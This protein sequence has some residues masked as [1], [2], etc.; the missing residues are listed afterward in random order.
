MEECTQML[1]TMTLDC[2]ATII[3]DGLDEL[4]GQRLDLLASL[5]TLID[6]SSSIV[7]ILIS[8]REDTDIAQALQDALS[9]RVSACDNSADIEKFVRYRTTSVI[10]NQKLLGGSVS[11]FLKGHLISALLE[12][13]GGMFLWP[14]LQL[15]YFCDRQIFKIE[16]DIM[17]ALKTLPPTMVGTFERL[18]ARID[19]Y[20]KHGKTIATRVF[21]WLLAAERA[22]SVSELICAIR[23]REKDFDVECM[24]EMVYS[25][26]TILDL[27]CNFVVLDEDLGQFSFVHASV[28]EYLQLLPEYS[29]S[30]NNYTAAK[31]CLE[32]FIFGDE[33]VTQARSI[34]SQGSSP[35]SSSDVD[36]GLD[37]FREYA[38]CHWAHH[39]LKT[40]DT[41]LK[42]KL[43]AI[44][45]QFTS[46]EEAM[47]FGT[48]EQWLQDVKDMV[49]SE[50]PQPSHLK[51]LNAILNDSD[52]PMFVACVYGMPT[53]LEQIESE[54]LRTGKTV[55]YNAKNAHGASALYVC[56][57]YG[58]TV[59]LQFLLHRRANTDATGGFFGNPL[60]ASAFHGHEDVVRILVEENANL[61]AL[62]KFTSAL[63]AAMAGGNEQVVKP[64]LEASNITSR[65]ELEK[66]LSR[67]SYDG[68]Y[69]VVRHILDLLVPRENDNCNGADNTNLHNALQMALFQGRTRI[70]N[71]MLKDVTDINLNTGH[72]GNALQAAAFGGHAMMVIRVLERKASVNSPGRYGTA[73]RA[74]ALRGHDAIVRLLIDKGA[75]IQG[76]NA[77]AMQAAASKG[78][79]WTT[80]LLLDSGIYD[81]CHFRFFELRPAINAACFR[82]YMDIAKLFL[83]RYGSQAAV[84]VFIAALDGGHDTIT[85][86]ALEYEPRLRE[87]ESPG[88][89]KF[90]RGGT[91]S[92]LPSSTRLFACYAYDSRT[93]DK[94]SEGEACD[95]TSSKFDGRLPWLELAKEDALTQ[96][97]F[98]TE[99]DDFLGNAI[100]HGYGDIIE[101]LLAQGFDVN[102]T[103]NMMGPKSGQL[104]PIEV[105]AA[106]GQAYVVELLLSK[107]ARVGR[108]L[109]YAVR[110][111]HL[112]IIRLLLQERPDLPVDEPVCQDHTDYYDYC[113]SSESAISVAVAWNFPDILD[114]LVGHARINSS[115]AVGQGLVQAAKK[116]DLN[117]CRLI[118][119]GF[120]D[121]DATLPEHYDALLQATRQAAH[122]QDMS[123]MRL[124]LDYAASES[125]GERLL[126]EFIREG[127]DRDDWYTV[128]WDVKEAFAPP[129]Y[130]CLPPKALLVIAS[131]NQSRHS[132]KEKSA[133]VEQ[134]QRLC[135]SYPMCVSSYPEALVEAAKSGNA[136]IIHF[137]LRGQPPGCQTW[138]QSQKIPWINHS[139][140]HGNTALY[141][142]CAGGHPNAFHALVEAG[143]DPYTH[144]LRCPSQINSETNERSAD[145]REKKVNLLQITLD[146][147]MAPERS[148]YTKDTWN[149]PLR[150]RLGPIV[151]YLLEIGLEADLKSPNLVKFFHISCYQGELAYVEKLL[152]KGISLVGGAVDHNNKTRFPFGSALHVAAAAG[153]KDVAKCLLNSGADVRL[154]A[155]FQNR[156]YVE[157]Q[158]AVKTAIERRIWRSHSKSAFERRIW[159]R[160]SKSAVLETCAYL[161]E[162]GASDSDA[163]IVLRDACERQ[164]MEIIGRMV[165]HG[166][167]VQAVPVKRVGVDVDLY[168][169][170]SESGYDLHSQPKFISKVQENA[171]KGYDVGLLARLVD[172]Y[173]LQVRHDVIVDCAR[174]IICRKE[175]RHAVLRYLIHKKL[176]DV[177]A[178]YHYW[179][180]S[181]LCQAVLGN[182][183]DLV[184]FLLQ[185]GANSDSPGLRCTPLGALLRL[186]IGRPKCDPIVRT[187]KVLLEYGADVHGARESDRESDGR[188]KPKFKTALVFAIW[189]R[190][191][192]ALEVV[193]LLIEHGA[194]INHGE[195]TPFQLARYFGKPEFESLL[196]QHGAAD[197]GEPTHHIAHYVD[198]LRGE[199]DDA[200]FLF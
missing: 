142:A 32:Y 101:N 17:R 129:F 81:D 156:N 87:F 94:A 154:K 183:V 130:D 141:Y 157:N 67:A 100:R 162:S 37:L 56:A 38:I 51:E 99:N 19:S 107:G 49:E 98:W 72:F 11:E 188:L 3:I 155:D 36:N 28:R 85:R 79:F 109:S 60:Q 149:L 110:N 50:R 103:G 171:I 182:H 179:P 113:G 86:L 189:W 119:R 52:S 115:L 64:L 59:S 46:E 33:D 13:A 8:S 173:G 150:K 66:V 104:T 88:G 123:L 164:N 63:D 68:H 9:V 69:E 128:L 95:I 153:Q 187:V 4:D 80:K 16:T 194:D 2:P 58:R 176:F 135:K 40:T 26:Q 47:T 160:P 185:E 41:R 18:Y 30:M 172:N 39:F 151:F 168:R 91:R 174:A 15:G 31:R 55:D 192:S 97:Y 76:R 74:A 75:S 48:F 84:T 178:P 184:E 96:D 167:W 71:R 138:A 139:D 148:R 12:G 133:M 92:L 14:A 22:L 89:P 6:E 136:D 193:K 120:T 166:A 147:L 191:S 143:A 140:G 170:L 27:C 70:A 73:L 34:S 53:I 121:S 117:L 20:G 23:L 45:K 10:A 131:K 181:I 54:A 83:Q 134:F 126:S 122:K 144:H 163:E 169:A 44:L 198:E 159:R 118:L 180:G 124:L 25:T 111:Q 196:L 137:L 145:E 43:D 165:L 197:H 24:T 200:R 114:L 57:R 102:T 177:N 93:H 186:S 152:T 42:L 61:F 132:D 195:V 78:F 77:D 116:R 5:R 125:T 112:Q 105:A 1:L 199:W 35:P 65:T 146:T 7:K 21:A 29:V 108:A 158:T 190:S 62:G 175:D 127:I 106:A 161:V 90:S 82:G